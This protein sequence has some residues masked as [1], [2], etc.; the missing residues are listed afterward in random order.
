MD[1]RVTQ[2]KTGAFGPPSLAAY[3]DRSFPI[4]SSGCGIPATAQAYSLN[5]TVVPSGPLSF[6]SIWPSN[7]SYPGVST[8]N[9]SDG[10]TLANAAIVPAG[11]DSGGSITVVAGNPTDLILD[12]NGYFAPPGSGLLFY[13][14]TQCRVVDTLASGSETGADGPPSLVAYSSRSFPIAGNC[15]I[16][17]S[18]QA[19]SLNFTVVPSGPLS[20]LSTWPTGQ[21]YP[22][23]STL[24]STEGTMIANSAIVPAGTG[25]AITVVAGNP[26]DLM[27]DAGGY[28]ASPAS[29]G[30]SFYPVTPCRMVD[31]RTGQGKTGAFGPPSLVANTSRSFP[32]LTAGCNIPSTAQVYALNVTVVPPGPLSSIALWPS[33]QAYPGLSTLSSTN[34]NVIASRDL[35]AAG[36]GG[37]ITVMAGNATDVILDITGYFAP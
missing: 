33:G 11:T 7:Q 2:G 28:F 18:A 30:L 4:L 5:V 25:G 13:P 10:S 9:S 8:I 35:V 37:A 1:T 6:L 14:V 17:S 22:G 20:F 3:S 24:N 19:F 23:V 15:G 21:S 29:G 12:V 36:A 34:G 32:L 16:P 27:I 31:T 26:T